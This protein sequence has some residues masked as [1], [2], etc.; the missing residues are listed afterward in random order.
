MSKK[1]L[2]LLGELFLFL[3]ESVLDQVVLFQFILWKSID[4]LLKGS[5]AGE[6]PPCLGLARFFDFVLSGANQI[7]NT[8]ESSFNFPSFNLLEVVE[9]VGGSLDKFEALL[10]AFEGLRHVNTSIL[11]LDLLGII[12][13]GGSSSLQ[14]AGNNFH[15]LN[16]ALDLGEE[17][18]LLLLVKA[19]ISN[20]LLHERV[21]LSVSFQH[22]QHFIV[23]GESESR[24]SGVQAG[25]L[26]QHNRRTREKK[27][28]HH[29]D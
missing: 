24:G 9:L 22:L 13:L 8:L 6:K 5:G 28:V 14:N 18:S 11:C 15:F 21:D 1:L 10:N 16:R 26:H 25:S 3:G 19:E 23:C 2:S 17:I 12:S 20:D 7:S 27:S 4:S 29:H